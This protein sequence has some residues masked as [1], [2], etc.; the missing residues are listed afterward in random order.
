MM[1]RLTRRQSGGTH[2]NI[3]DGQLYPGS[4]A[5]E[6]LFLAANWHAA[7]E[8]RVSMQKM[9]DGLTVT[10]KCSSFSSGLS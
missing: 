4:H 6:A 10:Q 9:L 2:F 8:Q 1:T 7:H 3:N 5:F